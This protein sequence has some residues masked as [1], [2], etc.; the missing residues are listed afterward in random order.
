[1]SFQRGSGVRAVLRRLAARGDVSHRF[2]GSGKTPGGWR[3]PGGHQVTLGNK[4][5]VQA[6]SFSYMADG[7][8][9]GQ[10]AGLTSRKRS[11]SSS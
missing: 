6:M 8:I 10:R 4:I 5:S 7:R 11:V 3:S 1:M 2:P 9:V